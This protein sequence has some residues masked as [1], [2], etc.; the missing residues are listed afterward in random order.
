MERIQ[1]AIAKARAARHASPGDAPAL[2][3]S[4]A[5]DP[6][7]SATWAALGEAT[8]NP[9][10]LAAARVV[11]H[12]PCPEATA[13][14]VMRTSLLT[15]LRERGWTRVAITSPGSACGKTTVC[16]NLAFSLA[17]Q[18]E[19]R[20]LVLEMDLRRPA[21]ARALGLPGE[22]RFASVLDGSATAERQ[23]VRIGANLA[24]G[25]NLQPVPS[26]AELLSSTQASA[27][28]DG[29]EA[30][31]RPDVILFDMP[32]VLLAD[33]TMAFL[34]Q[35]DCALIVAAA[36]QS[37]VTEIDRAGKELAGQTQVLGVVLNKCRYIDR[38]DGYGYEEY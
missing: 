16:L 26:P 9:R 33:D 24:L 30:R 25:V 35:V 23:L 8:L 37:T 5:P 27:A 19:L 38:G 36:E 12:V 15:Q 17:R 28:I 32:P 6:G 3:R 2:A 1:S 4:A 11:A 29:I 10:R 21:I 22:P 20:V 14:D 34:D 13:F 7:L 31:F 18:S